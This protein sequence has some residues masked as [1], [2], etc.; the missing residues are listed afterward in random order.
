MIRYELLMLRMSY[1]KILLKEQLLHQY[2][3]RIH[4]EVDLSNEL[5][6]DHLP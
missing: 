4:V 5:L 2:E 1:L 6:L 3:V